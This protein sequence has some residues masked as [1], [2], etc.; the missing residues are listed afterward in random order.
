MRQLLR[1]ALAAA[2]I[3]LPSFAFAANYAPIDCAKARSAADRTV[4]R[5][6]PLGQDEAR[7]ATLYGID[8]SL[9]AMGQR[10][11]IGDAQQQWI[12]R[13]EAC[14]ESVACLSKAYA[15]RIRQLNKVID[16]IASRGPY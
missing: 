16:D 6:Y 10:G 4:C 12:K 9:V 8:M 2:A 13:R 1:A 11:D 5:N 15:D 14:R 3:G 7:M